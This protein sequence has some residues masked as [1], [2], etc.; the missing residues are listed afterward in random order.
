M[1]SSETWVCVSDGA[2]AQFYHCDAPAYALEPVMGFGIPGSG[3][4]FADRLAGQLDRAA[5]TS[6]FRQLVMVGPE[7]V[8]RDVKVSMAPET[9]SMVVGAL[10][11]N[12]SKATPRELEAHLSEMLPH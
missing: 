5:R 1:R 12:L 3:R 10:E 2:H 11:K 7:P 6:L 9:L 4:T 8:L